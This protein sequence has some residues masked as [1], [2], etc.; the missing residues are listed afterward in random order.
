MATTLIVEAGLIPRHFTMTPLRN[1]GHAAAAAPTGGAGLKIVQA[2]MPDLMIADILMSNMDVCPF[3]LS[4]RAERDLVQPRIM[5]RGAVQIEDE[6]RALATA[7][8]VGFVPK[9][10]N[11]S[12]LVAE[13]DAMMA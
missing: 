6:A 2:D 10:V 12:A 5:L 8:G 4:L 7:M 9:P 1:H 13:V 3:M 11:P